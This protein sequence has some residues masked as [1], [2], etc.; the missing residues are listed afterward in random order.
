VKNYPEVLRELYFLKIENLKFEKLNFSYMDQI[1]FFM[2]PLWKTCTV[3]K[4]TLETSGKDYK[5]KL[6]TSV[7]NTTLRECSA[8]SNSKWFKFSDFLI[9]EKNLKNGSI[10]RFIKIRNLKIAEFEIFEIFF[11]FEKEFLAVYEFTYA[12][13]NGDFTLQTCG[14]DVKT[15]LKI[16]V[17]DV[18]IHSKRV[19]KIQ[20]INSNGLKVL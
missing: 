12:S 11:E 18:K 7:K 8:C 2:K 14:K 5:N 9:F 16:N 10:E 4:T 19:R 17:E 1:P 20:K 6:E 13:E 15:T 3:C